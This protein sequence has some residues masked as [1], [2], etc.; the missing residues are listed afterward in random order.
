MWDER[1]ECLVDL[2]NV[3]KELRRVPV[4]STDMPI[5]VLV[6]CPNVGKSSI[7]RMV[8]ASEQKSKHSSILSHSKSM[9]F[10]DFHA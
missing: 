7:V 1:S 10:F 8:M 3:A 4:L 5:V 6:G 9:S 2:A